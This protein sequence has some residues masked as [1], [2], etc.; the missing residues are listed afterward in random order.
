M[1]Y[2]REELGRKLLFDLSKGDLKDAFELVS[3]GARLDMKNGDGATALNLAACEGYTEMV[4]RLIER[5]VDVNQVDNRRDTPLMWAASNGKLDAVEKLIAA[6]AQ[7]DARNIDGET[8]LDLA[9][10]GGHGFVV[11]AL[12]D[13]E[14]AKRRQAEESWN[15][16][17]VDI[18][19]DIHVS[20]P[21]VLKP[22][23]SFIRI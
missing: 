13:I 20:K 5:G 2:T 12:L 7:V 15:N 11:N 6:G 19:R 22:G 1:T 14:I 21:L 3:Q 23:P 8:A 17:A 10:A 18:S 9:K 4:Q 16:I